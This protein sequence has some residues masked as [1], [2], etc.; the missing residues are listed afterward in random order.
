MQALFESC[1]AVLFH[2]LISHLLE[3]LS[4]NR[5]RDLIEVI[6]AAI[7]LDPVK[8]RVFLQLALDSY[9]DIL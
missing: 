9:V 2:A 1:G 3:D 7:S 8:S 6:R 4:R 5:M